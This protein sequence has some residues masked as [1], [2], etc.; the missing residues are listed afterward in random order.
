MSHCPIVPF[1]RVCILPRYALQIICFAKFNDH[2][3]QLFPK[4][5]F[6]KFADLVLFENC[7][8]IN[9]CFSFKSYSVFSHLYNL[10]TG[11]HNRQTRLAMNGLLIL[12]NCNTD[13]FSAKAFLC[14]TITSWNSFQALF[15]EKNF[16]ILSPISLK[17]LLKD[18]LISLYF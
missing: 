14:S 1:Y 16:G 2:T 8:F 4:I 9:K 11:R 13:K 12:A 7:V 6:K 10:A 17:N 18:Y 5:K 3:T 15:S